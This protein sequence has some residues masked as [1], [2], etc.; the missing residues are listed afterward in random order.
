MI[1]IMDKK[2]GIIVLIIGV[3]IVALIGLAFGLEGGV[4]K[5]SADEILKINDNVYK[6]AEFEDFIKYT[7]FKNNGEIIIDET[8][9]ADSI[10]NGTSKEDIFVSD[11]LNSFYQQKVTEIFVNKNNVTLSD[12]DKATIEEEYTNNQTALDTCGLSKDS[13]VQFETIR[14]ISENIANNPSEYIELP[15]DVYEEYISNFS[16]DDLKSY[17][18]R[19]IQLGYTNDTTSGDEVVSGD[20]AEKEAQINDMLARINNG[21]AFEEVGQSGDTRIVLVGNSFNLIKC[22]QEYAAGMLLKQK[23]GEDLFNAAAGLI[24]GQITRIVDTGNEFQFALMEKVEDGIVGN[25]KAELQELLIGEYK[26]ELIYSNIQNVEANNPA[27][28]RIKVK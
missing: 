2:T 3:V 22:D 11:T 10:A 23:L 7:L 28:N 20:K 25:A 8:A 27:L 6:K 21:E 17:T 5:M 13:Y 12:E 26:N 16:G 24:D 1:F 4:E 19:I 15:D 14:K 18:F 9:N